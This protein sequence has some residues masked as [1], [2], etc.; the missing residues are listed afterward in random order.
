MIKHLGIIGVGLIGGSLALALKQAGY[1]KRVTGIGRDSTRLQQAVKAGVI[2]DFVIDFA[3]G[4]AACDMVVIAVPLDSYGGVFEKIRNHLDSSAVITDVGSAKGSVV[5]D[6]RRVFGKL[7]AG[8]VPGHPIAGTEKSGF[9]AAFPE[10]FQ[11]RRVVLTPLENETDPKATAKVRLMWEATGAIV[12]ITS[13]EHHDRVLA[14]TSH[15]PHI[16]A[17]G[18][19][20][21][22]AKEN[23]VE[24]IF[25]FAA[26]G[27]RDFTRIAASDPEVWRDICLRNRDAILDV[28]RL[29]SADLD[30]LRAAIDAGDGETLHAI[31]SRAKHARDKFVL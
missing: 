21:S 22:L 28:M 17:F 20:D 12:E 24:E 10:L 14:A 23:D 18:L 7:P 26:G 31:F 25:R 19:V 2:D 1:C 6:V 8:F 15:L 11:R 13:V 29:Y 9:E 27:F 16:L 5:E 30:E 3:A 4:V